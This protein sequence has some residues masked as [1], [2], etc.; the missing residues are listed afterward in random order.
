MPIQII[1]HQIRL[2]SIRINDLQLDPKAPRSQL[3]VLVMNKFIQKLSKSS[4]A[5]EKK[6]I[7]YIRARLHD[8]QESPRLKTTIAE[9]KKIEDKMS[10]LKKTIVHSKKPPTNLF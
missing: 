4:N 5:E 9:I 3:R 2:M 6:K 10:L 7:E 8:I 1:L